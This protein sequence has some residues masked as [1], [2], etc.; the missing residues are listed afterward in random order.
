MDTE[1]HLSLCCSLVQQVP[2]SHVMAHQCRFL[3]KIFFSSVFWFFTSQSAFFSH[4][5]TGLP[6]MNQYEAGDHVLLKDTR[7][8]YT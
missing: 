5:V 6:G 1:T 8:S 2:K 7:K 3:M 4:A